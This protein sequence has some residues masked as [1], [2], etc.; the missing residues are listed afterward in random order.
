MEIIGS[1]V[2]IAV[3]KTSLCCFKILKRN[4]S[5]QKK[6]RLGWGVRKTQRNLEKNI[7]KGDDRSG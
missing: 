3:K 1:R 5:R 4:P 7:R 2:H 6:G